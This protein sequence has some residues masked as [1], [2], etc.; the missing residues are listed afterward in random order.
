MDSFIVIFMAI[1]FVVA[2]TLFTF[3]VKLDRN[4]KQECKSGLYD[5]ANKGL[6]GVSIV[7]AIGSVSNLLCQFRCNCDNTKNQELYVSFMLISGLAITSL[8]GI[9]AK[10]TSKCQEAKTVAYQI[11]A[12][13]AVMSALCITYLAIK[14]YIRSQKLKQ[15]QIVANVASTNRLVPTPATPNQPRPLNQ[16]RSPQFQEPQMLGNQGQSQRLAD[17]DVIDV[18]ATPLPGRELERIKREMAGR[19]KIEQEKAR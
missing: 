8:G 13:G 3:L 5:K 19:V 17:I 18:D 11:V 6:L 16:Q 15:K 14:L 4:A 2:I 1:I 7:L 12:I 9:L 10:E